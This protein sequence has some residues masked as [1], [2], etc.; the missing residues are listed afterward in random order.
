MAFETLSMEEL[1]EA[2][3][4]AIAKSIQTISV[5]QA[6]ELGE[7]LFTNATHPWRETFFRFIADNPDA[8]FYHAVTDDRVH[9]IYCREKEKGIWFIPGSGIG[10][11][12][13]KALEIL[14]KV[15]DDTE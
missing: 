1:T 6:K 9:V 13:P 7:G 3:R 15:A 2:R 12:Q 8:S 4:K 14:R 11:I 5:E 10:I